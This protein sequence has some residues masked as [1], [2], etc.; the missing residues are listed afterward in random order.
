MYMYDND[1]LLAF[2][3]E[4]LGAFGVTARLEGESPR[5][6]TYRGCS[7]A[8]GADDNGSYDAYELRYE[9]E[10]DSP[11]ISVRLTCKCYP[12]AVIARL[13]A[14]V[15]R[16]MVFASWKSFAP[17][18]AIRITMDR[19]GECTGLMAIYQHK[20]WWLR[21][22]IGTSF[23]DIPERS[24]SLLWQ[25]PDKT[26]GQ[27]LPVCGPEYR[28]D[29]AG[30]GAT[31]ADGL[32]I[33]LSSGVGG[34]ADIEDTLVFVLGMSD[35]P[36]ALGEELTKL[37]LAELGD[38]SLPRERKRYPQPFD[39]LGWCSWDAFY[40]QVDENGLLAKAAE[41]NELGL[42]VRWFM[43]DDGWLDESAGKLRSFGA[44][45]DKF[46]QGIGSTIRLLKE[47]HALRWVGVWHTIAGY[48][49]GIEPGSPIESMLSRYLRR[50]ASGSLLPSTDPALGFG[51][52]H[53]WHG[54]LRRQGVDFVK[55]DSQSSIRHLLR[56]ERSVGEAASSAHQALEASVA[57]HFD[58]AIINCMGMAQENIWHRPMSA[59]SRNSDDYMPKEPHGF[60][61]HAMQNAY[62]SVLHG[63]LYWGD[64]DMFWSD[65][66]DDIRHA[67]L[68]AVSG[69]PVYVSDRVG[70]TDPS[71]L[72]P[73]VYDDGRLLRCDRPALPTADCLTVD[74]T[75]SLLP[76]KLWNTAGGAGIVAAFHIAESELPVHGYISAGDVPGMAGE[77][78]VVYEY[79]SKSCIR[80]EVGE[81]YPFEL[82]PEE[83]KLFVVAAVRGEVTPIGL[84][85]KYSASHAVIDYRENAEGCL[86]RLRERSSG[87]FVFA[88]ETVPS[89]VYVD[90]AETTF[91][92]IGD[93]LYEVN[94]AG[95]QW[96]V[97]IEIIRGSDEVSS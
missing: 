51:F 86:V 72:L 45:P 94:V 97:M 79:F 89:R 34:R 6:L 81:R 73:L 19:T 71:K 46:P 70:G 93:R 58:G 66:R 20:D 29:L 44:Q 68:R 11:E 80:L 2:D 35:D 3:Q 4:Q 41:L 65:H 54:E 52:W 13:S 7:L 64:W 9:S 88:S 31:A 40:Q 90:R 50:T 85:N 25:T 62:N 12:Q 22:H 60:R 82:Q 91:Q 76:L 55:V 84:T 49:N 47:R 87:T 43:I 37:A 53:A 39:Y 92:S 38:K 42:P 48:W 77:R 16:E 1:R 17:E 23:A 75:K 10:E 67:V 78:V 63:A 30:G 56:R 57:L 26:Y 27:L 8:S 33:E 24:A 74:P 96:P 32:A 14:S 69:G 5:R 83:C 15:R 36:Y 18:G 59:V 61:E 95:G 21:P 28:C